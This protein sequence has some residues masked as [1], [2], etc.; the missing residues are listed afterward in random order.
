MAEVFSGNI[1]ILKLIDILKLLTSGNKTGVLNLQ[2]GIEKGEIYLEKG[3][4]THA[5]CKA[6][7]GEEAFFTLLTWLE[8]NFTFI[9]SVANEEKSIERDTSSILE[10]G[11]ERLE[12]WDQI[13]EI[14]PSQDLVFKLSALR[15]PDEIT[16]K[17]DEWLI[18][19]QLDGNR[20]VG[21]ISE[22]LDIGEY[23]TARILYTLFLA[24]LIEVAKEL[25]LKS[26]KTVDPGFFDFLEKKL[27]KIIGP[28]A[29]FIVDEEI[30]DMG[31]EKENFSMEKASMLVEKIS[32]EITN[33]NEKIEFQ[34]IILGA[35]REI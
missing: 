11:I 10:E 34:E 20:T 4:I 1:S 33:D 19:S 35:L 26:K 28:V 3:V 27:T 17:H 16:I 5:I 24:G 32:S 31:E 12:E 14:I 21:E 13:K 8:G 25:K 6:G 23:D 30:K 15:A 9:P 2:R 7:V 29:S 18:L 22:G